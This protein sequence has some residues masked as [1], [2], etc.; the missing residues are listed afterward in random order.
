MSKPPSLPQSRLT[1]ILVDN[2]HCPS[3]VATVQETLSS[4]RP[5][6]FFVSTSIVL[7]EIKVTHPITL[8]ASRIARTLTDAG[9]ELDSV[10]TSVFHDG[11]VDAHD[12]TS[13]TTSNGDRDRY[14][15]HSRSETHT[16]QFQACKARLALKFRPTAHRRP[17]DLAMKC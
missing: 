13:R 8:S 7:H 1:V 9:F 2:L 11:D 5:V 16:R 17:R 12:Y 3:C 10:L 15:V 4:L 6:V 14:D